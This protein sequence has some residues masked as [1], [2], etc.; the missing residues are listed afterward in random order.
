MG[1]ASCPGSDGR[2]ITTDDVRCPECATMVELFSDEQ[3]RK[4]PKCGARVT[5][6]VAP[7]CAAWCVSARTCLGAARYDDLL[8]SGMLELGPRETGNGSEDQGEGEA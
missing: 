4:C 5:R 1:T 7:V 2:Y 8:Q 6:K 3:R